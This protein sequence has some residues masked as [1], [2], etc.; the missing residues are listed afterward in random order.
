MMVPDKPEEYV[1]LWWG[2]PADWS[3][4]KCNVKMRVGMCVSESESLAKVGRNK[5]FYNIKQCDMLICPSRFSARAYQESPVGDIPISIIPLG[6]D[7]KVFSYIKRDWNS[8]LIYLM[9]GAAQFRKGTWLGIEG[10]LKAC[11][12]RD[13]VKLVIWSSV[14]T[15]EREELKR[16]YA[17]N[18][19][20][21]FD[22]SVLE[23]PHKIYAK[24]H[25]ILS[26][27][28][29]EGFGLTPFEAMATGMPCIMSRCSSPMEYFNKEYGWWV[30]MSELY[31]PIDMCIED[32]G[33][34]WRLPDVD[35]I[36]DMI[37]YSYRHRNEAKEKGVIASRYVH[38]KLSWDIVTKKL[39]ATIKSYLDTKAIKYPNHYM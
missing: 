14:K 18:D 6:V 4:S 33:G 32:T 34:S 27:H 9:A 7:T 35:S 2:N 36:A 12:K 26:P 13:K 21:I 16:E 17:K 10:F 38:D 31:A 37:N 28:L 19:K 29:S 30:E 11:H 23:S 5:T 22:D 1:E 15:P 20:I 39:Y 8:E 25:I 24:S 3:W